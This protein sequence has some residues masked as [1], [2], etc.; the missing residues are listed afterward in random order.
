M[1]VA[2][3]S[4]QHQVGTTSSQIASLGSTLS[5]AFGQI[6][7]TI[8]REVAGVEMTVA[9]HFTEI[10][11][12]TSEM[13]A[14]RWQLRD[15]KE[16]RPVPPVDLSFGRE[17]AATIL[18]SACIFV[19][20]QTC[21]LSSNRAPLLRVQLRPLSA[22]DEIFASLE[23]RVF[24]QLLVTLRGLK[25]GGGAVARDSGQA[26]GVAG[27]LSFGQVM[28]RIKS[29]LAPAEVWMT[30]DRD[31]GVG[32]LFKEMSRVLRQQSP[33]LSNMGRPVQFRLV[34]AGPAEGAPGEA[35]V[36]EALVPEQAALGASRETAVSDAPLTLGD[37][38]ALMAKIVGT[39]DTKIASTVEP[40]RTTT[41]SDS[42]E[43]VTRTNEQEALIEGDMMAGA[44]EKQRVF[45]KLRAPM[46][47]MVSQH[48]KWGVNCQVGFGGF[49][50]SIYATSGADI[51][52][53]TSTSKIQAGNLDSFQKATSSPTG[54]FSPLP[55]RKCCQG[56]PTQRLAGVSLV[57]IC[58][59]AGR[60]AGPRAASGGAAMAPSP[61]ADAWGAGGALGDGG[62]PQEEQSQGHRGPRDAALCPGESGCL[63]EE[64]TTL[65]LDPGTPDHLV[66]FR[67]ADQAGTLHLSLLTAVERRA[68]AR[69]ARRGLRRYAR[70]AAQRS[71]DGAW[72]DALEEHGAILERLA[73]GVQPSGAEE[74]EAEEAAEDLSMPQRRQSR[75]SHVPAEATREMAAAGLTHIERTAVRPARTGRTSARYGLRGVVIGEASNPGPMQPAPGD[76][77]SLG[78]GR[79]ALQG[80]PG[81]VPSGLPGQ[82][83]PSR[84]QRAPRDDPYGG[85]AQ[86]DVRN[87][88]IDIASERPGRRQLRRNLT[89]GDAPREQDAQESVPPL[90]AGDGADLPSSARA[91][92]NAGDAALIEDL[93]GLELAEDTRMEQDMGTPLDEL[94]RA[95]ARG[96]T[97][98]DGAGSAT[99]A[100]VQEDAS[101]DLPTLEEIMLAPVSTR[102]LI[103]DGLLPSVEREFNKCGANVLMHSRVD[104]WDVAGT[105][106][107]TPQHARARQAWTE[108]LMFPKTVTPALPGGKAKEK[109][110]RNLVANMVDRWANGERRAVWDEVLK[111][112][113]RRD[114]KQSGQPASEEE[115]KERKQQE[116]IALARR[117]LP[118]KAVTHA[119][120]RRLAPDSQ[121]TE[122]TMRSKFPAAP[123]SQRG[124]QRPP[125]PPANELTDE[126]VAAA[127]RSFSRGA[128]PGP[129]GHRPDFY[130]QVVGEKGD[131]P[132]CAILSGICNLLA[133]GRAPKQ[134]RAYL[135]GARGTALRKTAKDGSDDARPVCSG[136]TIRRVVG[137][138]LLATELNALRAHLQPL[139]LAVGVRAGAEVMP[140]M[141]RQ[142]RD[143][144]KGDV[145]RIMLNS[146]QANAHNEEVPWDKFTELRAGASQIIVD[147]GLEADPADALGSDGVWVV[148]EPVFD[149]CQEAARIGAQVAKESVASRLGNRGFAKFG[150]VVA[151]LERIKVEELDGYFAGRKNLLLVGLGGAHTP[152][153]REGTLGSPTGL[154]ALRGA[155]AGPQL[156]GT[157]EGPD[158][159]TDEDVRTLSVKFN[160]FNRRERVWVDSVKE[161]VEDAFSDWPLDGPR[162]FLWL[163]MSFAQLAMVPA[164]WLERHLQT[165]GWSENDRSIHEMRVMAE[166]F[167]LAISYD[168]LNVASLAA[169]ER[170]GRRWQ[171]ILEAH[172]KNPVNPN[173][174]IADKFSGYNR[175]AQLA[176]PALR[177]Y[178]AKEVR[179]EAEI[180]KQTT[181]AKALRD[182]AKVA[183]ERGKS[184]GKGKD[185]GDSK[186]AERDANRLEASDGTTSEEDGNP[187]VQDRVLRRK[188]HHA[189]MA[190]EPGMQHVSVLERSS[191]G[192]RTWAQYRKLY[193]GL[194]D[195]VDECKLN[196]DK[197]QDFDVAIVS[198][199]THVYM[200]GYDAGI[201]QKLIAAVVFFQPRFG[202][203]GDLSHPRAWR[204]ARG[205]A[206]LGPPRSRQPLTLP[207]VAGLA[208][209]L[210]YEGHLDMAIW[211]TIAFCT[212][213]RPGSMMQLTRGSLV[214]PTMKVDTMWRV[215]AHRSD[216]HQVSKVGTQDDTILWD[217]QGF[218]WMGKVLQILAVGKRNECLWHF[219]YPELV[220]EIRKQGRRLGQD[221]VPYQLR[222]AG[223]SLDIYKK[224]RNLCEVQR[225]GG[226]MSTKSVQRYE[227]SGMVMKDYA[228]LPLALRCWLEEQVHALK[229]SILR[230]ARRLLRRAHVAAAAL[231]EMWPSSLLHFLLVELGVAYAFYFS[232]VNLITTIAT[233]VALSYKQVDSYPP[234]FLHG[235]AAAMAEC[236]AALPGGY[237]IYWY[238]GDDYGHERILLR[239]VKSLDDRRIWVGASP[240]FDV[241]AEE[242]DATGDRG[243]I[244]VE[245]LK[246]RTA[247]RSFPRPIY[248]FD[249]EVPWDKFTELRAEASQIIVD[250]GLEE[251][252]HARVQ[253]DTF[254][255][256]NFH[257]Q[258]DPADALGSDGVWVVSEPVFDGGQEVARIGAQVAKG[259]VASRLGNRGFAKFGSVV[260]ALER[261]K[262]G[263]LD[264]YFA[265]R[266]NLLLVGLGGAHTPEE[267]EG[268]LGSPTG[269]QALRGALAAPQL[270][271][272]GEGPDE[273]TD[274]DVRTLSVKFNAFNRRERVWVDS[275]KE[276]VEDAFSDWPLDGPRT[277]LWLMMSFA[278]LAMVP[279]FW[280]ERHLQTAGWSEND[281]SIHEMRVMAE[282]FELAISYDQLNVAS[283][284]AFER[285]GRRWRAILEAH[286]KNPMNPNYEIADKFS[287][288]NRRAQLAAPAL[289]TYVAKE[290]REG[291]EI[292]K[293]TTTAKALRDEAKV[294]L[295]RGKSAGK[296]KDKGDSKDE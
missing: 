110:N 146:D 250:E 116:V 149:G 262:A 33:L 47:K 140:H 112:T 15:I 9:G 13:A 178:V 57:L 141:A 41:N 169:F 155:L 80:V 96:G 152:E 102:E 278:Q 82:F 221:I 135:G 134:L 5:I 142:W 182:E 16:E 253:D 59:A 270:P 289:R 191:V 273:K 230:G 266:K 237:A 218:E 18:P 212:Y 131:K 231:L 10:Q 25:A 52:T 205:W 227:K 170:S 118:G 167:E 219:T 220:R 62:R 251:I 174:E 290:V 3:A 261:I 120:S 176:A 91:I 216:L 295:K 172:G 90:A 8:E 71:V 106:D 53:F 258:A 284:A 38:R 199:M 36:C 48:P 137:K 209:L 196:A 119:S 108:W 22:L 101:D 202:K 139:Q 248:R 104:A 29:L 224:H 12:L 56:S 283:L 203:L 99:A 85:S 165:A 64:A 269:L 126:G 115:Q 14:A 226:W 4:L 246:G 50:G 185:K 214:P 164:F 287:G 44:R 1:E 143:E 275:V 195:Y 217:T 92:R 21:E 294:A 234:E 87:T 79:G 66:P 113:Q 200:L 285:L 32:E 86:L 187:L 245:L 132:G 125:A 23:G 103:G 54:E 198:F 160:A 183:L 7:A 265:G 166:V 228:L 158:K 268:A 296:G 148:S 292:D 229:D 259:S 11:K 130:K 208:A 186:E 190:E 43:I 61:G 194:V 147:E 67:A 206:K 128:A 276:M 69:N 88:F 40:L 163:M 189:K 291:A 168:Q 204:A 215:L 24:T 121:Q 180:D 30:V 257:G 281:R 58:R 264:G 65:P 124:S 207:T 145:D 28:L 235:S 105:S 107:D 241:Y 236:N 75:R 263:E 156:P 271:G 138:A 210:A 256:R 255:I 83:G 34:D 151:A 133:D 45:A 136:E 249:Q 254:A 247:P 100:G 260:A 225:R 63:D 129:S 97:G 68:R 240:D 197:A 288:Y 114:K 74:D 73:T 42:T 238:E 31:A 89:D 109:R 154:Q 181:T 233:Q 267:R 242:W 213:L 93:E 150:S 279:A 153:E 94:R 127:I 49:K 37:M 46:R 171:A 60:G 173:Y 157:G 51:W 232:M 20:K 76:Q 84:E 282:V 243:P 72:E 179:E 17:T 272:T 280:L 293:Q 111:L 26:L 35:P 70:R 122:D 252:A 277:F 159:K 188:I 19:D 211:T 223:A 123:A 239:E 117:G 77:R 192:E 78:G 98:R 81:D 177:T 274:E 162:A 193:R 201:G 55:T 286:G 39:M 95:R 184:A 27:A 244:R 161:M 2:V 222:H 175:R 144:Y 6:Q